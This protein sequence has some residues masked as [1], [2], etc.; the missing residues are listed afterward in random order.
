MKLAKCTMLLA[1][2]L[3]QLALAHQAGDFLFAQV[4]PP[5]DLTKARITYWVWAD[6][7]P[8]MIPNWV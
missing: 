4:A 7:V 8:V 5:F 3:P 2:A 1:L 6:S